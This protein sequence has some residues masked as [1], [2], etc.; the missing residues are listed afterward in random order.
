MPC[1]DTGDTVQGEYTQLTWQHVAARNAM[2]KARGPSGRLSYYRGSCLFF[3]RVLS[4]AGGEMVEVMGY[5]G[6]LEDY[7]LY[8]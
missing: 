4:V 8:K 3:R 6:C 7:T 1:R 5:R 2:A